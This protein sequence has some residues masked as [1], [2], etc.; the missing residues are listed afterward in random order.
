MKYRFFI[1]AAALILALVCATSVSAGDT[2]EKK[3]EKRTVI[4]LKTDDFEMTET[5]ISDLEVGESETIVTES[6]K[7]IDLLRTAESVEIYVDG[8]LLE[9]GFDGGAGEHNEHGTAHKKVKVICDDN[10]NCEKEVW[11]LD[12]E[13]HD[14]ESLHGEEGGHRIIRKHIEIECT[15]GEDCEDFDFESIHEHG[16][17]HEVI[18][19]HQGEGESDV[20]IMGEEDAEIFI[21]KHDGKVHVIKKKVGKD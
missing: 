5:D 16:D 4:A 12:G 19:I 11:I 7:T 18:M 20:R 8:E 17:A 2:T 14:I 10:E 21:E 1:L 3:I 6:G 15:D 13:D 9:L